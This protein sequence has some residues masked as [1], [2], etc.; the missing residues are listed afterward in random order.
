M[1]VWGGGNARYRNNPYSLVSSAKDFFASAEAWKYRQKL[2][3][4]M[5]ARW[6]HTYYEP[7]MPGYLAMYHNAL[8]VSLV[9]GACATPFWWSY[10]S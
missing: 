10:S 8:W 7:G 6:D 5:I 4:Y 1:A 9:N 3:R 2:C